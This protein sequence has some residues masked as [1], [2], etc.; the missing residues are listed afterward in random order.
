[1]VVMLLVLCA[2]TILLP[3]GLEEYD[4]QISPRIPQPQI[5]K[6][7]PEDIK[8]FHGVARVY[9]SQNEAIRFYVLTSTCSRVCV[10]RPS[11]E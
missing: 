7:F 6:I 5:G 10:R 2:C 3:V 9:L 4:Y 8:S 1:M 11:F